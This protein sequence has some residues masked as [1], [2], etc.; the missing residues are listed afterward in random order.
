MAAE[1]TVSGRG[2][3]EGAAGSVVVATLV[4]W[5]PPIAALVGIVY[6]LMLISEHRRFLQLLAFVS[7]FHITLRLSP[8]LR[9]RVVDDWNKGW[10]WLSVQFMALAAAIQAVL[11]AFPLNPYV[12]AAWMKTAVVICLAA[13]FIGRFVKQGETDAREHKCDVPPPGI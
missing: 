4:Q 3:V 2:I 10:R 13:A 1:I 7:R 12:P 6:Y 8:K 5:L 11:V 9:M